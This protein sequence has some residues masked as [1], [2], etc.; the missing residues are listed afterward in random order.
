MGE[1]SGENGEMMSEREIPF[2]M[3]TKDALTTKEATSANTLSTEEEVPTV[4]DAYSH[5]LMRDH[6]T[7]YIRDYGFC[8]VPLRPG[9]KI[10]APMLWNDPQRAV[11]TLDKLDKA[12][13]DNPGCNFGLLH[14]PSHTGTGDVDHE[15]WARLVFAEFGIDY[16]AIFG[17]YPRISSRPGRDK[18][19]F[20]LPVDWKGPAKI[21][22]TWPDDSGKCDARGNPKLVTVF[23]L[24]AGANQDVLPPSIHP[25]TKAPYTWTRAL[26]D[27]P[28]GMPACPQE[29]MAIW[30]EWDKTFR[31]QFEA[32]C[33][34]LR[35]QDKPAPPQPVVRQVGAHSNVIGKFN[36]TY[37][38]IAVLERNGYRRKGKRWLAPSSSTR[39][40][41]VVVLGDKVYSHHA[42]DVLNNGHAH[43]A[44]SVFTILEHQGDLQAALKTASRA[45]GIVWH[46]DVS[47]SVD[48]TA[49]LKQARSSSRHEA[50]FSSRAETVPR[51]TAFQF[52]DHLLSVPG[53]VGQVAEYINRTALF[54]QPVL[55]LAASLAFCGA[56]MGRKVASETD[57]RTNIYTIGVAPSGSGKE[58]ARKALKRL[59]QAAEAERFIGAEKLASDQGLFGLLAQAPACVALMDEFGRTLRVMNNDRAPAHLAQLLTTIM[60]LT[61]SADSFIMEK[62]RAEHN[63]ERKP[64]VVRCPN[65]CIYATTVPGRL[66]QGLTPDEVTDGFLPRFLVFESP[67]PDPE[68]QERVDTSLPASLVADVHTWSKRSI[69]GEE[70]TN[71]VLQPETISLT[72]AAREH[73]KDQARL[74]RERKIT[75]RGSG[76]DALWARAYEHALRLA[77]IRSAGQCGMIELGDVLWSCELTEVLLSRTA[78][79]ASANLA[80]NQ[81]ESAVQKVE[82]YVAEKGQCSYEELTRKFR[83]LRQRERDEILGA[84]SDAGLV[85]VTKIPTNGRAKFKVTWLPG[86]SDGKESQKS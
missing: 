53:L 46:A 1:I 64:I 65:F 63:N 70:D 21:K 15:P 74:W 50:K 59:A 38:C 54:P 25:D 7:R 85:E 41:G 13:V 36:A 84:L 9:T 27:F 44:F 78:Q 17:A 4:L 6:A 56:L 18:I 68:E 43:D 35:E 49:L 83:W 51:D 60:E 82:A 73:L 14:E 69:T 80:N 37:G 75:L 48:I 24:R 67:T 55:S 79:Q 23:E 34:W 12:M 11:D 19:V 62:R 5:D 30:L 33:P 8:L 57:L 58:H 3:R 47:S 28:D 31:A 22:L 10:P 39:I 20:R 45:L 86:A 77:L 26:W 29:L 72:D 52:P 61:G 81:H 2:W 66:Y 16:D 42:S 76:L 40:P 71:L 32:A